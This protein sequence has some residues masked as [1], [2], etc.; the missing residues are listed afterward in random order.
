[1]CFTR[2]VG[3]VVATF[4]LLSLMMQETPFSGLSASAPMSVKKKTLLNGLRLT[5]AR[6]PFTMTKRKGGRHAPF[7]N[8]SSVMVWRPKNQYHTDRVGI[9]TYKYTNLNIDTSFWGDTD[10]KMDKFCHDILLAYSR[11]GDTHIE[12]II[13]IYC[14]GSLP[15]WVKKNCSSDT[16]GNTDEKMRESCHRTLQTYLRDSNTHI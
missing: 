9:S 3:A 2:P 12:S 10:H 7:R 16:D 11:D 6:K 5:S 1:M 4:C 8:L 15:K 14:I 13:F